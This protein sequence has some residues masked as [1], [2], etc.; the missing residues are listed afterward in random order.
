MLLANEKPITTK[1]QRSRASC[2]STKGAAS[3]RAGVAPSMPWQELQ[4]SL[5]ARA[6]RKPGR[7]G[8]RQPR[9]PRPCQPDPA[10]AV[11]A[12]RFGSS[13]PRPPARR[14][15]EGQRDSTR[16][17]QQDHEVSIALPT[18]SAQQRGCPSPRSAPQHHRAAQTGSARRGNGRRTGTVP[19]GGLLPSPKPQG[20]PSATSPSPSGG[21]NTVLPALTDMQ[22]LLK[23]SLLG[24]GCPHAT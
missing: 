13:S 10:A 4:P 24:M 11:L 2:N 3:R 8:R 5:A 21:H 23:P 19:S 16:R 7:A 1:R 12:A 22:L 17:D 9:G 20:D 15:R 14:A 6:A 18:P